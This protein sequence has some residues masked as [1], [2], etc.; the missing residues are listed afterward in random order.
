MNHFIMRISQN[1][2]LGKRIVHRKA[3][4]I[5]FKL[6]EIVI[7]PHIGKCIVHKAHV[8]LKNVNQ[9]AIVRRSVIIG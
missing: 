8:P 4:L 2:I 6:P 9:P 7:H 5:M 3:H 1:I